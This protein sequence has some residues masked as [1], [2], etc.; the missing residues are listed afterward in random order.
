MR[1]RSRSRARGRR[2]GSRRSPE[3]RRAAPAP[4]SR[5]APDVHLPAAHPG[6]VRA[7]DQPGRRRHLSGEL[8]ERDDANRDPMTAPRPASGASRPGC[9]SSLVID[10]VAGI[11]VEPREDGVDA[12]GRRAGQRDVGCRRIRGPGVAGASVRGEAH[13]AV[14]V[15][16]AAAA[17][18]APR[19][20][21]ARGR[22][23]RP[24]AGSAPRCPRSDRTTARAPGTASGRRPGRSSLSEPSGTT[25]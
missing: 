12:V 24:A 4:R 25:S 18:L 3:R 21:S 23:S 2:P 8:G 1:R 14:E 11:E 6:H 9:S 5:A 17:L 13:Q 7:G 15:R 22:R 10:L 20:R 19:D 16:T